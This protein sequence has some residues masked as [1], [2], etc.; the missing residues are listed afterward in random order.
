MD[1]E[2]MMMIFFINIFKDYIQ[3]PRDALLSVTIMM[4][5]TD[6]W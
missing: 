6:S 2:L 5:I 1:V 4:N 3:R